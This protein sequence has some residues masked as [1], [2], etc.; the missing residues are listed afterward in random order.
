MTEFIGSFR[1]RC[2]AFCD[3]RTIFYFLVDYSPGRLP[4]PATDLAPLGFVFV[5]LCGGSSPDLSEDRTSSGFSCT[6]YNIMIR[7]EVLLGRECD[8]DAQCSQIVS[9]DDACSTADR[10]VRGDFDTTYLCELIDEAEGEGCTV[11]YP[12]HTGDCDPE[13]EPV[14][15]MGACTWM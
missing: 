12:G 11:V 14:C 3:D 6:E 5:A 10:I 8:V 1:E 4:M 13:A 9:V 15:E 7:V 2:L